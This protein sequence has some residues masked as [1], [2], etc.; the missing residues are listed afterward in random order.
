MS[1]IF[2]TLLFGACFAWSRRW[3][4]MAGLL[5]TLSML[6]L[7]SDGGSFPASRARVDQTK[8]IVNLK[9]L[10]EA[11][12]SWATLTKPGVSTAPQPSD[13]APYL[14]RDQFVCPTGGTYT[15]GAV[16]EPP[17]CSFAHLGHALNQVP[18]E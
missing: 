11:K 2:F 16:N 18:K 5:V 14:K 3:R 8:C 10:A 9:Q 13:L 7:L 4:L 6:L 1:V 17:R 12:R 15:L